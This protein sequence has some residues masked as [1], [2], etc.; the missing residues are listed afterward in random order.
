MRGAGNLVMHLNCD[1]EGRCPQA[2]VLTLAIW[3]VM[4]DVLG[5]PWLRANRL[6]VDFDAYRVGFPDSLEEATS[7]DKRLIE[8]GFFRR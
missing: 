4:D 1:K 2:A 8:L 3:P 6:I 7:E 5:I